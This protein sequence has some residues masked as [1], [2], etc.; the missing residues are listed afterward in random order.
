MADYTASMD[1]V[2]IDYEVI[3]A[4]EVPTADGRDFETDGPALSRMTASC[5]TAA[6][7]RSPRSWRTT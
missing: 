4:A 3:D 7:D 5:A 2:G 1:E 6:V